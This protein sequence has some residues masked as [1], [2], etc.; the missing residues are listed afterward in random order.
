MKSDVKVNLSFQ[1]YT[2]VGGHSFD[3]GHFPDAGGHFSPH[4]GQS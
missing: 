1:F 4:G 2:A 3:G